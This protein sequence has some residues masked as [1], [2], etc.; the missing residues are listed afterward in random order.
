[1][2]QIQITRKTIRIPKRWGQV[3]L[4]AVAVV[5]TAAW[6][7]ESRSKMTP[8]VLPLQLAPADV[9][10]V[11]NS[12]L[13]H[14]VAVTGALN[15]VR[16]AVLNARTPGEVLAVNV[17]AGDAVQA[18]Q[19]LAS[20]DARDLR[21][22][23]MQAEASLQGSQ[24]EAA[25]TRQQLERSKPLRAS[26]YVSDSE[27]ANAERQLDIRDAQVRSAEAALA[28]VRQQLADTVI[29]APFAG[30]IAE[31][32]VEPGQGVMSG[33]PL[34]KMVDL[35]QLELEAQVPATDMA[36]IHTGQIVSFNVDGFGDRVFY[37][38]VSRINPVAQATSRRIP[39]YVQVDNRDGQLRAGIFAK[40]AIRDD[41]AVAGLS[42][43]ASALQDNGHGGWQVHAVQ[44]GHLQAK[45]VTIVM[46]DDEQGV[47][48]VNGLH[49]GDKV[50]VVPPLP[51]N[52]G[53]AVRMTGVQ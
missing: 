48:L 19:V 37:G 22:R 44:D 42:I 50:L 12:R 31:R 52:V 26:N 24:A 20:M 13:S 16:Q 53:N 7:R 35:G 39:V 36:L 1:M 23:V 10:T 27:I 41:K 32:L 8:T 14:D 49:A 3:G 4:V 6:P 5:L 38:R 40:G 34:L 17:R 11:R 2:N 28:Q 9:Q 30:R 47:A 25:L 33:S 29:R 43:P 21:L 18:G 45:P 46:R 15:P 51:N